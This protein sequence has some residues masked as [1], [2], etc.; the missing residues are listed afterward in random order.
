MPVLWPGPLLDRCR[1]I[2]GSLA[3]HPDPGLLCQ[4]K[5]IQLVSQIGN[6]PQTA[7]PSAVCL[8][9]NIPAAYIKV[10]DLKNVGG[11]PAGTITAAAYCRSFGDTPWAH[12]DIAGTAWNF[13]ENPMCQKARPG[14]AF[15]V[16]PRLCAPGN[17]LL[18]R[19][20]NNRRRSGWEQKGKELRSVGK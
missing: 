3:H 10:A 4:P 5:R 6:R 11:R 9:L 12:W 20:K 15:A 1:S 8:G 13:T 18:K 2:I 14:L 17:R 7:D 16:W 19:I